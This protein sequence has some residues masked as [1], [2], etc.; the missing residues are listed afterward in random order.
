MNTS[1]FIKSERPRPG[2]IDLPRIGNSDY[3]DCYKQPSRFYHNWSHVQ[4]VHRCA[5]ALLNHLCADRHM[6]T[7]EELEAF[8]L[9]IEAHDA[10]QGANHEVASAVHVITDRVPAY[11]DL[12]A[13]YFIIEGTTHFGQP[14]TAAVFKVIAQAI[15]NS[16]NRQSLVNV[17]HDA[18]LM[19]LSENPTKYRKYANGIFGEASAAG[20]AVA[21]Y[22]DKRTHALLAFLN[23]AKENSLYRTLP[24]QKLTAAAVTNIEAELAHLR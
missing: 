1:H 23:A 20:M 24:A 17:L 18:D 19:I 7:Q 14:K 10:F 12:L 6:F 21:D 3:L 15:P 11:Q 5:A 9:A 13:A 4:H 22:V 8:V 2:L 16:P